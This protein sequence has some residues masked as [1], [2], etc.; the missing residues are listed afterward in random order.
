MMSFKESKSCS[1]VLVIGTS[2]VVYPAASIPISAK[3]NG[4]TIIEINKEST[5]ITD[6][7]S[8]YLIC[9][10]A[11]EIISAIVEEVKKGKQR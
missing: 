1:A 6:E 8:D 7:I 11:G 9:G 3:E 5:P 4:A 10:S 2:V